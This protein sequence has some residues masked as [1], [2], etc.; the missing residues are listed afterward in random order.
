MGNRLIGLVVFALATF[1]CIGSLPAQ[2]TDEPGQEPAANEEVQKR[3]EQL[4]K[5]L[6]KLKEREKELDSEL[7]VRGNVVALCDISVDINEKGHGE[8]ERLLFGRPR[9]AGPQTPLLLKVIRLCSIEGILPDLFRMLER[10]SVST[11]MKEALVYGIMENADVEAVIRGYESIIQSP[12]EIRYQKYPDRVRATVVSCLMELYRLGGIQ[13]SDDFVEHALSESDNGVT[14]FLRDLGKFGP[15]WYPLLSGRVCWATRP[16]RYGAMEG[17]QNLYLR[18]QI[19][20]ELFAGDLQ[21][22]IKKEK[23]DTLLDL[24]ILMY[25]THLK[26]EK[27]EEFLRVVL[28]NAETATEA[29]RAAY[30]L[31]AFAENREDVFK[32]L[33]KIMYEDNPLAREAAIW[34]VAVWPDDRKRALDALDKLRKDAVEF[35]RKNGLDVYYDETYE[36]PEGGHCKPLLQIVDD[37]LSWRMRYVP[38]AET[39]KFLRRLMDETPFQAVK[40]TLPYRMVEGMQDDETEKLLKDLAWKDPS[41]W[42]CHAALKM[43]SVLK[44][45]EADEFLKQVAVESEHA[46]R[47]EQAIKV[48]GLRGYWFGPRC[49]ALETLKALQEQGGYEESVRKALADAMKEAESYKPENWR[50]FL[51]EIDKKEGYWLAVRSASLGSD[52]HAVQSGMQSEYIRR[53]NKAFIGLYAKFFE[54]DTKEQSEAAGK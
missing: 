12:W 42:V 16:D 18:G 34:A 22:M 46:L 17:L 51:D 48:L 53:H 3:Q 23:D 8:A 27:H 43:Y 37:T 38:D 10:P 21:R 20:P 4:Q 30:V 44:G 39:V 13:P 47:Q 54:L 1:F 7:A 49:K 25:G 5:E 35:D 15:E 2:D 40:C 11:P 19:S 33:Q 14:F 26:G 45:M 36:G 6:E 32:A 41:A 24:A 52:R 31:M 9:V 29:G 50:E 28:R